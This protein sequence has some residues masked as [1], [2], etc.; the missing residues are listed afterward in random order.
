MGRAA[1]GTLLRYGDGAATEAFAT[2]SEVRDINGGLET[3]DTEDTTHQASAMEETVGT[4]LRGNDLT[5]QIN[6][7]PRNAGHAALRTDQQ[8]ATLRNF[9]LAIPG[10]TATADFDICAFP[11]LVLGLSPSYA[12]GSA[13]FAD[14][15]L[16]PNTTLAV[17]STATSATG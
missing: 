16:K 14:V 7:N 10:A 1:K 4:I 17:Y 6:H 5:L 11:A 9:K 2:L 15:T 8:N 13:L 12:V 3:L